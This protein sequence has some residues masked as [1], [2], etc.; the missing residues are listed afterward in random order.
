MTPGKFYDIHFHVMD[1]SHANLMATRALKGS[2]ELFCT[3]N[4]ER[5]LFG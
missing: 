2:K 5:F 1:L 4:P 3:K